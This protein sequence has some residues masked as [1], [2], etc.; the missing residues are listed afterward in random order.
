MSYEMDY[1][2]ERQEAIFAGKCALESLR[3]AR[4]ESP[5]P[6]HGES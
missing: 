1:E 5:K 6:R 3:D 4:N 2:K